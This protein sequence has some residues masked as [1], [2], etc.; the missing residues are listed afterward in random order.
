M[1]NKLKKKSRVIQTDEQRDSVLK[2]AWD[3]MNSDFAKVVP[4]FVSRG[5]RKKG[6]RLWVV[7]VITLLE[8]LVLGIV[9][10]LIY[11]WLAN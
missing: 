8:L 4:G 5:F 11:E 7:V 6:R 10:K 2:E 1:S 3:N 9:G